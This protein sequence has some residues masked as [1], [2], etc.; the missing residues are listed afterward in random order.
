MENYTSPVSAIITNIRS[1]IG[2]GES[3]SIASLLKSE[4]REA[5][6]ILEILDNLNENSQKI[7]FS[8]KEVGNKYGIKEWH[9]DMPE[10]YLQI[11]RKQSYER[12]KFKLMTKVFYEWLYHIYNLL[13][14]DNKYITPEI[15][16]ELERLCL[17]RHKG[18]TH[19][20]ALEAIL[21]AYKFTEGNLFS[22]VVMTLN[23]NPSEEMKKE[24]DDFFIRN[25]NLF[26]DQELAEKNFFKKSGILYDKFNLLPQHERE[27]LAKFYGKNGME[28]SRFLDTVSFFET[29][30]IDIL[31]K[32]S[33]LHPG[34]KTLDPK[35]IL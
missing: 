17:F 34:Q 16:L 26:D 8:L 4:I 7:D 29:L 3:S 27:S 25:K 24:I 23:H 32:I 14:T 35:I 19:R 22:M 18:V 2:Y 1:K 30:S 10:E 31:N 21:D 9:N 13:K 5:L 11:L 20:E 33:Q 12:S 28:S 15:Y 6:Q